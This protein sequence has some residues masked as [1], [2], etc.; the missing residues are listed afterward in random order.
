M[1]RSVIRKWSTDDDEVLLGL[2]GSGN[3]WKQIA[4]FMDRPY[5]TCYDRYTKLVKK[6]VEWDDELN[7]KLEKLYQKRREELWRGIANELGAP[8]KAVE[9]HAFDLGKKRLVGKR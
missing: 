3:T 5:T 8:W 4:E 1:P 2:K 7:S 6:T 9:D